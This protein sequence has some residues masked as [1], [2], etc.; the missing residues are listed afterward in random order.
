M[1]LLNRDFVCLCWIK[2]ILE[3][4]K[5]QYGQN[6]YKSFVKGME[7]DF[8]ENIIMMRILIK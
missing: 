4:F 1:E 5:Y 7:F 6:K 8:S 3:K 2:Y